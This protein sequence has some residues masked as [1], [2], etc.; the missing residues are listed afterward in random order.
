MRTRLED[1]K[2]ERSYGDRG[3]GEG[4]GKGKGAWMGGAGAW[5]P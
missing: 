5:R 1:E 3:E 4:R 2:L